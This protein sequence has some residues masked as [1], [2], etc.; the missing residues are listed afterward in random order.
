MTRARGPSSANNVYEQHLLPT[1][2]QSVEAGRAGYL[3][4]SLDFLRLVESQR[5][6]LT[7][8]EQ[9]YET[10]A[11]Y[12]RRLAELDRVTGIAPPIA[13]TDSPNR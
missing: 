3:A 5:Q 12:Q 8:Q 4:G 10:M 1:A 7:V 6:S 13:L 11:E 9:Y 2:R